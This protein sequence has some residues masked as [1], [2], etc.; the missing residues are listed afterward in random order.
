MKKYLFIISLLSLFSM[1]AQAQLQS[2]GS[3]IRISGGSYVVAFDGVVNTNSATLSVDG[4][5]ST[6]TDLTNTTGATLQGDGQ[7]HIGG[8]WT[9]TANFNAGASTVTF[10]GAQHSTVTSG[11][12]AFYLLV[13]NKSGGNNL[14]LA[15]DLEVTNQL[16][17]QA[18]DNYAV[19]GNNNL[20]V[21]D[22]NGYDATR[23]VRTD[24]TGSLVRHVGATPVEFPVGN[25]AYNPATLTNA[26]TPDVYLVRVA[27]AVLSGGT[28]G[29]PIT[30]DAVGRGWFVEENTAGGSDLS[31][32]LQW[33]S[34]EEQATFDRTQ[35]YVSHYLAGSWDNQPA[36]AAAGSDPYSLIRSGISSVGPFAVFDGDFAALIGIS[37]IILWEHDGASGVKDATVVLTGDD[38]DSA[39]TPL[40]GTYTLTAANGSNFTVTPSKNINKLNG[41]TVADATAIQQHLTGYAPISSPYKQVAA[42]VNN[43]NSISTLDALIIKQAL[44]GNPTA[45]NLFANSWRFVPAA[46]TLPLPPW[47]FPEKIDLTGVGGS[48]S[49]QDFRGIKIG[50]VIDSYADP[51]NLI[52]PSP[53]VLRAEDVALEAGQELPVTFRA[54]QF[55]DL[56]A[57]QFSLGFDRDYLALEAVEPLGELPLT[58]DNFARPDQADGELRSVWS[59]AEGI[60][61]GEASQVFQLKFKVLEGGVKLRDVLWLD[62][63][64]LPAYAYTSALKESGIALQFTA[65]SSAA[66]LTPAED[67][68]L[69]QNQPNPFGDETTIGFVLPA[70]G[71]CQA[72][73]R[74]YDV[75]GMELW[76]TDKYYPPGY[77]AERI[78][79]GNLPDSRILYCELTTPYGKQT[80][81]MV[82]VGQ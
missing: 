49:G 5:L 33:N 60:A 37:G 48:V 44:L 17:F 4:T 26:G 7:Y 2:Q 6:P 61:L 40:A 10:E 76:R 55:A 66:D 62:E 68:R 9:N 47:G 23:H 36:A 27:D 73:L 15:D 28:T 69:L 35:A 53:L 77:H 65:T 71:G 31:L 1:S 56:V 22:L 57:W 14:L 54:D 13:L 67:L 80:K 70:G 59:Q 72:Q 81:I 20:E 63:E 45:L 52:A 42:D 24:G 43:S 18:A 51:S 38:T 25:S 64:T 79:L 41:V 74:I 34:A 29:S 12:S 21:A 50:D 16:D 11:G 8:N 3:Y 39:L 32:T 46:Y 78:W 82:Q 30:A 58:E 19:L 75:R